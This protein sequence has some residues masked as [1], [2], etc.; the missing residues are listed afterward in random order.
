MGWGL[1]TGSH[2][3]LIGSNTNPGNTSGCIVIGTGNNTSGMI[4]SSCF[5][6]SGAVSKSSGSFRIVHPDPTKSETKDLWHSFVESPNEGDNLY[7]Y[8]VDVEDCRNVIELPDYYQHLNKDD[9]VWVSPVGH[10]GAAY[11]SVTED[12]KCAVVCTNA[13]GRYNVLLIGTRK[14]PAGR[15]AWKGTSRDIDSNSPHTDPTHVY[16]EHDLENAPP[17]GYAAND[18]LPIISTTYSRSISAYEAAYDE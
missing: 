5:T 11:A 17:D 13:D 8:S 15:W 1:S 12:Q 18:P 16:G 10:F 6:F 2:N 4:C 9:M 7:R 3:I 14:D